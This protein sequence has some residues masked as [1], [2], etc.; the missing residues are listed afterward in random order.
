MTYKE[1]LI[2]METN[3]LA[4]ILLTPKG[5]ASGLSLMTNESKRFQKKPSSLMRPIYFST[6]K[7][8][9]NMFKYFIIFIYYFKFLLN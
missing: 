5:K 3:T 6:K 1:W 8:I 9:L 4:T 2:T 7:D